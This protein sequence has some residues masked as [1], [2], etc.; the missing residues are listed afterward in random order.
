M[1]TAVR[2]ESQVGA[3][4]RTQILDAVERILA[5]SG[6]A[7]VTSRGVAE[8]VGIR[9][10]LVHY[11]FPTLD[12]LF[13]ATFRRGAEVGLE[14]LAGA[15]ASPEP[16]RAMWNQA[17]NPRAVGWHAELLAAANHRDS[18]RNELADLGRRARR[19]QI[20]ALNQLL[21]QYGIDPESLPA[22]FVAAVVQ[23]VAL[24]I[25]REEHLGMATE[26]ETARRA[27]EDLIDALEEQRRRSR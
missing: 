23:G 27:M 16:L 12:D 19:M 1:K 7:A 4:T 15:L 18:V 8:L 3:D 9:A 24:L 5:E 20:E 26:H 17:L 13:V 22:A 11:Y 25:G 2:H 6:Y 21:P 10:S 14:R